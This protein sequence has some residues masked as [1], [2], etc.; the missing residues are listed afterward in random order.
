MP[1]PFKPITHHMQLHLEVREKFYTQF[2]QSD[3]TNFSQISEM[4]DISKTAS[5]SS[6]EV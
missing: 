6:K 2:R 3:Q 5:V 1:L 4:I